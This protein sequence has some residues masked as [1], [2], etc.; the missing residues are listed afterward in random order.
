MK[1]EMK[2]TTRTFWIGNR[3]FTAE[4]REEYGRARAYVFENVDEDMS[5]IEAAAKSA[6][7]DRIHTKIGDFPTL[8][9]AWRDFNKMIIARQN[10]I[11]QTAMEVLEVPETKLHF[12]VKQGC[13]CGCSPGFRLGELRGF[14]LY[15]NELK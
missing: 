8:D 15:I 13:Q 1:T 3:K 5:K 12:S 10:R 2:S 7:A 11:T 4:K 9:A 6:G 14:T